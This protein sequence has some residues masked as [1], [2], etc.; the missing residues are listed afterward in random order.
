MSVAPSISRSA[1]AIEPSGNTGA[2]E[3]VTTPLDDIAIESASPAEPILP[4]LAIAIAPVVVIVVAVR[5]CAAIVLPDSAV[6]VL[7]VNTKSFAPA[8]CISIV[9]SVGA[10][11]NVS[12]S[13]SS[14]SFP[15]N[16]RF[17]ISLKH[18]TSQTVKQ[19]ITP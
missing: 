7:A 10:S 14:I 16:A 4:S 19:Q 17:Y 13:S 8:I 9:S 5:A 18:I 6:N 11:I 2:C 1:T 15:P 12:P 3:N